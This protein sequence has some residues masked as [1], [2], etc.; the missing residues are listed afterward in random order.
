MCIEVWRHKLTWSAAL[1]EGQYLFSMSIVEDEHIQVTHTQV[2]TRVGHFGVCGSDC[3]VWGSY[4]GV[5]G[6]DVG[7]S[8]VVHT[9]DLLARGVYLI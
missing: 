4:V 9:W 7:V 1:H 3:G 6:S 8:G 5:W 2:C